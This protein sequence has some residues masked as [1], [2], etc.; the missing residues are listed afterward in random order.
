MLKRFFI[1]LII[2]FSMQLPIFAESD[3]WLLVSEHP[4]RF[5]DNKT[6]QYDPNR[7][8]ITFWEKTVIPEEDIERF[9]KDNFRILSDTL[10]RKYQVKLDKLDFYLVHSIYYK[11]GATVYDIDSTRPIPPYEF[12]KLSL[13]ERTF[14]NTT[15][16]KSDGYYIAHPIETFYEYETKYACDFLGI[17]TDL[18]SRPH[19]WKFLYDSHSKRPV[20]NRSG[21]I[22]SYKDFNIKYYICTDLY[23]RNYV[24]GIG[25]FYVKKVTVS[26]WNRSI[27]HTTGIDSAY[28][29]F[30]ARRVLISSQVQAKNSVKYHKYKELV[31]DSPEEAIY[32]AALKIIT[33]N[34]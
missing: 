22:G 25:K 4:N 31:P 9:K 1:L 17:H 16:R 7:K 14:S 23:V 15:E 11:N 33:K 2:V 10:L 26:K 13:L 27:S 21:Q 30:R 19:E 28:I 18:K 5:V 29:D 3:R 8:I 32:N 24:D 12:D 20:M 6:V 34:G